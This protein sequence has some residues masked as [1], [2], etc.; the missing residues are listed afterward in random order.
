MEEFC[1]KCSK[2]KVPRKPTHPRKLTATISM[3]K[4]AVENGELSEQPDKTNPYYSN[5]SEISPKGSWPDIIHCVFKCTGCSNIFE[6]EAMTYVG[7]DSNRFGHVQK[8][9]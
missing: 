7:T 1:K 8:N 5:F 6:L 4:E 3:L 9:S 2:H